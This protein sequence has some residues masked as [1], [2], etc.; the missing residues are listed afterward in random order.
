MVI[1]PRIGQAQTEAQRDTNSG[2]G[3]TRKVF[4][5]FVLFCAI[6]ALL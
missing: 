1:G 2:Q 3:E 6:I 5:I 4:Q